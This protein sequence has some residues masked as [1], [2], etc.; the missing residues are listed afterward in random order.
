VSAREDGGGSV[1]TV[2]RTMVDV[3]Q[4][5]LSAAQAALGTRGLST[6]VSAALREV[7]RRSV[8]AD[9]DVLRDI[10]GTPREVESGRERHGRATGG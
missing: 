10:E 4:A 6:T 5:A 9:F 8:L 2:S 1:M 3:N 7:T